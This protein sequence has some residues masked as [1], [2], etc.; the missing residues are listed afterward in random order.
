MRDGRPHV[1]LKIA[2]SA[3]GKT[4]LAGRHPAEISCDTSRAEAHMLRATSDAVMVGVGTVLADDP[5]LNCR[6]PGMTDRSPIR[7]V[8]DGGLR[9]PLTSRLVKTAREIPLWIIARPDASPDLQR[10]FEA[11]GAEVMRISTVGGKIDLSE[12]LWNLATR[13]LTRVLVEGG[14]IIA[15][16]LMRENLVDEAIVVQSPK[17]LGD[18]A[19]PALEGMAL[20]DLMES[21]RFAVFERRMLG[22][23]TLTHLFRS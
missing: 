6:L 15:A 20:S 8:L 22:V 14:P 9:T 10:E 23:D 5:L 12:A 11:A 19:I 21:P 3:D 13:G 4:G 2:V 16:E 7:I 18:D 1:I 17:A